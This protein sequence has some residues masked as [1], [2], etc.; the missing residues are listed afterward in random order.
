MKLP[1]GITGFFTESIDSKVCI[2]D[3]KSFCFS[4]SFSIE[5]LIVIEVREAE[6]SINYHQA[7]FKHRDQEFLILCNENYPLIVAAHPEQNPM[8]DFVFIDLEMLYP[9][10]SHSEFTL[11]KSDYVNTTDYDLLLSELAPCEIEE[12]K[13]WK[14]K[15]VGHIIFNFFD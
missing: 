15:N 1:K 14:P 12:L 7:L 11:L 5:E 4:L 2:K 9:Q 10:L 8:I 6:Y 3:F 13:Y